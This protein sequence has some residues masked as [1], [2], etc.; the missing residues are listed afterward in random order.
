MNTSYELWNVETGNIIG[1]FATASEALAV[2]RHL[3]DAYG[4]GYASELTLGRR[5]GETL[6]TIVGDGGEL[7]AILERSTAEADRDTIPATR[8]G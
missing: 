4:D 6:A 8:A 2:V 7:V 1:S 3:L 5:D